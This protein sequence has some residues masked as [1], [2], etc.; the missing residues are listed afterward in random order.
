MSVGDKDIFPFEEP[1]TTIRK[2]L[3]PHKC[4]RYTSYPTRIGGTE[5]RTP[6]RRRLT[7]GYVRLQYQYSG[8][9]T[10]E[11]RLIERFFR[12]RKGSYDDFYS[13]DWSE[14]YSVTDNPA[15][16]TITLDRTDFLSANSGYLGNTILLYNPSIYDG[17]TPLNDLH[18]LL[19][20][21]EI[22]G[23]IITVAPVGGEDADTDLRV[24]SSFVYVAYPSVFETEVLQP[25]QID[26]CI[27]DDSATVPG[28]GT[29][30]PFG[31][32]VDVSLSF[33]SIGNF[34]T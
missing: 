20:I 10:W 18:Q 32:I 34:K 26:S 3:E 14:R 5:A 27:I 19:T 11:Y 13:I 12:E 7:K 24:T 29:Q 31:N 25:S 4:M 2:I 30:N 16:T 23:N 8:I 15:A 17:S 33:M 6:Y 1:E 9:M 21:S 28:F 22:N